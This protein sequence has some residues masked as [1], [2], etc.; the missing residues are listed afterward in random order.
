MKYI[1]KCSK[2]TLEKLTKKDYSYKKNKIIYL[3]NKIQFLNLVKLEKKLS[4]RNIII[5]QKNKKDTN[6]NHHKLLIEKFKIYNTS[7]IIGADEVGTSEYILPIVVAAVFIPK[8][9]ISKIYNLNLKDS[10]KLSKDKIYEIAPII[11]KLVIFNYIVLTNKKFNNIK[12]NNINCVKAQLF[13]K[14]IEPLTNIIHEHIIIDGFTNNE[15]YFKY[16]SKEK[17]II[18]NITLI[19]KADNYV[20]SVICASIIAKYIQYEELRKIKENHNINLPTDKKKVISFV[21]T[22]IKKNG[23]TFLD[24]YTKKKMIYTKK[25]LQSLYD[26]KL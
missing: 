22:N 2:K 12:Y 10:K 18:K 26:Q 9:N 8:G 23:L 16:L 25:I 1:I 4:G 11:M 3:D 20:L 15:N 7:L 6:L 13:N 5:E 24:D 17:N 21:K 19:E 14:T